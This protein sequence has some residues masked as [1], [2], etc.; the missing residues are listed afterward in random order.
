MMPLNLSMP[1]QSGIYRRAAYE[2]SQVASDGCR[3][4]YEAGS[5]D[6]ILGFGDTT[7][8]SANMPSTALGIELAAYNNGVERNILLDV[9]DLVHMIKVSAKI[10]VGRIVA[11]PSPGIVNL[12]PAEFVFRHFGVDTSTGIAIPSPSALF[13]QYS[14]VRLAVVY[15]LQYRCQLRKQQSCSHGL[16]GS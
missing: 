11:R 10:S 16:A 9:K 13:R 7:V 14:M 12:R 2:V 5:E 3:E 4:T 1:G 15:L 6:E 8:C